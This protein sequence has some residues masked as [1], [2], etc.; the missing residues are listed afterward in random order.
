MGLPEVIVDFIR[1][2]H[3]T[4]IVEY[5]YNKAVEA[6]PESKI[7]KKDF[8]YSGPKPQSL[9][10][11]ILMIVDAVE[12]TFRSMESTTREKVEKMIILNIVK[13]IADGQFDECN[14]S[15]RNIAKIIETLTDSLEATSHPRVA[16]P[17]QEKNKR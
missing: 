3:G 15:T 4:Q 5:F 17:W 1:Q 16:Y 13:R 12:A 14:L 11:A 2:H 6:N 9:E 10:A 8:R 7:L